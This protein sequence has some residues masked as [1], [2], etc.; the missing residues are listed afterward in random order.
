VDIFRNQILLERDST[1][2][3]DTECQFFV[4]NKEHIME[5]KQSYE[6][7][8]GEMISLAKR[9]QLKHKDLITR[10]QVKVNDI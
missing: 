2:K 9:R 7:E 4:L 8:I 5:I 10:L 1:A 6:Q 3:A